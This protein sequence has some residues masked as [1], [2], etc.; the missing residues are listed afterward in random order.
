MS[1]KI[2]TFATIAEKI[3]C[4]SHILTWMKKEAY[5]NIECLWRLFSHILGK[6]RIFRFRPLVLYREPFSRRVL[7]QFL[8][9]HDRSAFLWAFSF[10]LLNGVSTTYPRTYTW[11]RCPNRGKIHWKASRTW[12]SWRERSLQPRFWDSRKHAPRPYLRLERKQD[13]NFQILSAIIIWEKLP[14]LVK[15]EKKRN[16]MTIK[17]LNFFRFFCSLTQIVQ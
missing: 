5:W 2:A 7:H 14:E 16:K 1:S 3:L 4:P 8:L 12:P 9:S 6:S 11:Y 10:P 15:I 17:K 13:W